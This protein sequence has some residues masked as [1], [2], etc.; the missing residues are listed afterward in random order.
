MHLTPAGATDQCRRIGE[1]GRWLGVPCSLLNRVRAGA[2]DAM[3]QP[4]DA[5]NGDTEHRL[6]E[7][8]QS[9]VPLKWR[10]QARQRLRRV[11]RPAYMG[12]IRRTEPLSDSWGHDRG[13]PIDRYYI[14]RFL[15]EHSQ[16]IRGRTLEVKDSSYVD[17]FGTLI[18]RSDVLD[19]DPANPRAT[20]VADLAAAN[21]IPADL[22][23]CFVLTQTLQF[24]TDLRAAI[25]HTRR[26]LRPGGILLATVPGLSRV[27]RAYASSDYWR[28]TPASCQLLFG[29]VFGYENISVQTYGNVLAAIAFLTGIAYEE[30]SARELETQDE[31]FPVVIAVRAS[32]S[33]EIV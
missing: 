32:K 23:D 19:V 17:Q 21:E 30:L 25:A 29:E 6:I 31:H 26:I 11:V 8:L 13:T 14:A 3:R 16:E 1:G 18:E 4:V 22:F 15:E 10:L 33:R 5:V 9:L 2:D 20:I 7:S 28:F 12:T 24:V 27:E